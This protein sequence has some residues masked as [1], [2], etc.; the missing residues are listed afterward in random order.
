M[1]RLPRLGAACLLGCLS[2]PGIVDER[3]VDT[4]MSAYR[5]GTA[6][7]EIRVA[8]TQR[9]IEIQRRVIAGLIP[10]FGDIVGYKAALTSAA[11][12]ARF[13]AAGPV[14]GVLLAGM[15]HP[16]GTVFELAGGVDLWLEADLLLRVG[17]ASI[18]Q[19]QS[20]AEFAGALD[21]VIPFV[22]VPDHLAGRHASLD[23]AALTAINAGARLGVAGSAVDMG[24]GLDWVALLGR[25]RVSVTD[26]E[27][28]VL[29]LGRGDAALGHPLT[30]LQWVRDQLL[31][32][33][34]RL[35]V[36]DLVSV[37]ALAPPLVPV[38]GQ[39]YRVIYAG[40][41]AHPLVVLVGF[42]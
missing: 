30:A 20:P 23:A 29:A 33:G 26:G 15:L 37:G 10:L 28:R 34:Q 22:E 7:G 16:Q 42:R 17:D 14:M 1:K 18:N 8:D 41:G 19:A 4:V 31:A 40:L 21:A 6:T 12:Q 9:A 11:A 36:G 39:V 5:D 25:L 2:T 27:G 35:R 24:P 3:V 13:G 32:R 38:A